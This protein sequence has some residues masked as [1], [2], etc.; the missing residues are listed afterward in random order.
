MLEGGEMQ[1]WSA[2]AH[3]MLN[4]ARILENDPERYR[5]SLGRLLQG[6]CS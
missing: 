1:I 2:A 5:Y 3:T 6:K 4:D